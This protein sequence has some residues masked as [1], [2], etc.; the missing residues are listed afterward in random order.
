MS[1]APQAYMHT[2][3]ENQTIL[4]DNNFMSEHQDFEHYLKHESELL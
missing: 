1:R 2:N 4:T 3:K